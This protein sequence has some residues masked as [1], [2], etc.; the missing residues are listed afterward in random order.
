M[1]G[2]TIEGPLRSMDRLV[3]GTAQL[4][5]DYGIANTQGRPAFEEAVELVRCYWERGVRE[6]D[7]AQDYGDSEK[8]LG[9]VFS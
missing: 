2:L 5:M 7:T 9:R 3:L 1:P 6:F 8:I 4:G